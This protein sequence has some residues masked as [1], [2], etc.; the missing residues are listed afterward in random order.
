MY[1]EEFDG[2]AR[3]LGNTPQA[4]SHLALISAASFL[5]RKLSG[6]QALW[7]P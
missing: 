5:D 2:H 7:Q 6:E 1:A 3:H 4:L